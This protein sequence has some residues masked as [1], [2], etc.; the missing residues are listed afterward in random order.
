MG[1]LLGYVLLAVF[2]PYLL[3]ALL[4]PGWLARSLV[5][6]GLLAGAIGW[7]GGQ[8][9][10]PE[11]LGLHLGQ[12]EMV[13]IGLAAGLAAMVR[14]VRL[15]FPAMRVFGSYGLLVAFAP[16]LALFAFFLRFGVHD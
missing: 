6:L 15:V 16:V 14:S 7:F 10:L 13:F 5:L 2:G 3:M 8:E 4:P 11:R 9:I 1:G 12:P